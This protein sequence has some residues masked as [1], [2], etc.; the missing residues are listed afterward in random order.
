MLLINVNGFYFKNQI[1]KGFILIAIGWLITIPILFLG[2]YPI[3]NRNSPAQKAKS[4]LNGKEVVAYKR[5]DAA[6]PINYKQTY[7]VLNTEKELH[8][9]LKTN[10][11]TYILTNKNLPELNNTNSFTKVFECKALFESHVTK[12]YKLN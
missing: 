1:K 10:P 2:I 9:Y 11:K 5:F 3:L 4:I 8:N 7:L 12:I 6:F